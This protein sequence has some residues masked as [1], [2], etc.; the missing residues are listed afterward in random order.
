MSYN[1]IAG[2]ELAISLG[3][4]TYV[5]GIA[6]QI[7]AFYGSAAPPGISLPT[8]PITGIPL[9]TVPV[10]DRLGK[11]ANPRTLQR[12]HPDRAHTIESRVAFPQ[13]PPQSGSYGFGA[14]KRICGAGDNQYA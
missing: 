11:T 12:C 1:P 13:A 2:Q 5:V 7:N 6:S 3:G 10:E 4:A 9:P 8:S 14:G